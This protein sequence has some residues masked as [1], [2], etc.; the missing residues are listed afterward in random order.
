[1][2]SSV[3]FEVG[4]LEEF[5]RSLI[6]FT[7]SV[8]SCMVKPPQNLEILIVVHEKTDI[9]RLLCAIN[10]NRSDW[11]RIKIYV[12]SAGLEYLTPIEIFFSERPANYY[13]QQ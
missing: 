11:T 4:Q 10:Y 5:V 8:W 2:Y 1:M 3:T 12:Y 6:K 13:V 9:Y 7:F